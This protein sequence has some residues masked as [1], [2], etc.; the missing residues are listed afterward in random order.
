MKK[1]IFLFLCLSI[2]T[3]TGCIE[4]VEELFLNKDGSGRYT[5]TMDM[6]ALMEGGGIRSMLKEFG[7]LGESSDSLEMGDIDLD[8]PLEMDTVFTF[9]DAPDSVREKF[10]D[11]ELLSRMRM[12]LQVSEA[13]ETMAFTFEF[14][15][16]E[17]EEIGDFYDNLST[18]QEE[19]ADMLGQ[20]SGMLPM[21]QKVLFELKGR[22]L[23]R[24]PATETTTEMFSDEE[25]EFAQ[26][27][28][29]GA[30]YT[31]IYHLPGK[32]KKATNPNAK[33]D[34]KTV[35]IAVPM[36]EVID[37]KAALEGTIKFKRR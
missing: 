17:L 7:D 4:V 3:F 2:F 23:E 10:D 6:S 12:L 5:V 28:F 1:L 35:T 26:M 19:N 14:D 31:T 30:N 33:V 36:L 34:G 9:Q 11:P 32:V 13:E 20:Q 16:N 24:L 37:G 8:E 22:T 21:S 15:F 18:M 25:K 27:M 29:A